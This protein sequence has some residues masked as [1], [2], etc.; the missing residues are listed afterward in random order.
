MTFHGLLVTLWQ[1]RLL[2]GQLFGTIS[3]LLG[4]QQLLFWFL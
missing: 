3:H 2:L 1:H 4:Q